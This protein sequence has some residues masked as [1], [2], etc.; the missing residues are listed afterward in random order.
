MEFFR[1]FV[2]ARCS[3]RGKLLLRAIVGAPFCEDRV[4]YL[5]E[6]EWV[7]WHLNEDGDILAC[8]YEGKSQLMIGILACSV[9]FCFSG[10]IF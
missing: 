6:S 2:K 3:V 1:R 10:F 9:A 5:G 7:G 4:Y 8:K